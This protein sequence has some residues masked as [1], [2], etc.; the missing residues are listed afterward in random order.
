M[1]IDPVCGMSV[2]EIKPMYKMEYMGK[3]YIFCSETCEEKFGNNP[4]KY[5][6]EEEHFTHSRHGCCC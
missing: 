4:R 2:S 6:N 5:L 3:T 1:A